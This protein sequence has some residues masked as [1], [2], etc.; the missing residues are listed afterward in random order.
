MAFATKHI[1]PAGYL[2]NEV[3][4]L[5]KSTSNPRKLAY[6]RFIISDLFAAISDTYK[7]SK[8]KERSFQAV[9]ELSEDE[10][11]RVKE[12][13]NR[14]V[15]LTYFLDA[16]AIEASSDAQLGDGQVIF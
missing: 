12:H 9:V 10:R 4:R 11:R 14:F 6:L 3:N 16:T 7:E 2:M 1:L 15:M 8:L 5:L 13:T